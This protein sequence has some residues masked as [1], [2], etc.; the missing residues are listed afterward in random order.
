MKS[1]TGPGP[2]LL[3]GYFK[4]DNITIIHQVRSRLYQQE[5]QISD[6]N[7]NAQWCQSHP[8]FA[9]ELSTIW[10]DF[11]KVFNLNY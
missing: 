9:Y 4:T 2:Q 5:M 3:K 11:F 6:Y 8:E 10:R 7:Y 1:S